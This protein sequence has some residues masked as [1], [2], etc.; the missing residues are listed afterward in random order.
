MTSSWPLRAV[1]AF[2]LVGLATGCGGDDKGDG[3]GGDDFAKT[4]PAE[5]ADAAKT[6]MK[7]LDSVRYSGDI[8][9][10][11]DAI[12]L[13][14]QATSGGDCTGTLGLGD[15]KAELLAKD[16]DTWFRP[17]EAFWRQQAPE[18]ADAIIAAV[19]D[20][21]VVDSDQEFARF[22][23]L[24]Q[25]F[26]GV[27]ASDD[28]DSE[29]KT[30]GTDELDGREVVKVANTSAEGTSTGYVVVDEPHYLLKVERTEGDQP[31][32]IEFSDFDEEFDVEAPADD[33]VIDLSQQ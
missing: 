25:F 31:G 6:D 3:G 10:G 22:C 1:V 9:S 30:V 5:I 19:G 12:T 20:K 18:Q 15:G 14:V 29:Y 33:E 2:M 27:F 26:E 8:A 24:D 17:D 16:G 23:D 7:A 32:K 13:D 21:W 28:E 11:G 4:A